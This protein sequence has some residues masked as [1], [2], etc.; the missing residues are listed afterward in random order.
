M[1]SGGSFRVFDASNPSDAEAWISMWESWPRRE[2]Q[3][4]PGYVKLF[5][6]P[7]SR[8]LCASWRSDEGCV[9][10]PL[11][12]RDAAT[13]AFCPPSIE[14]ATDIITPYG[15][16][17]PFC[18]G[19]EDT[20]SLADRFWR[21]FDEW[22]ASEVV[23]SEF[24]RFS[25]F[26]DTLLD[27][28]GEAEYSQDNI[29]RNLEPD[30]DAIIGDFKRKVRENAKKA[31]SMGATVEMDTTGARLD[32]FLRI[33]TLT[34]DRRNALES[35]YFPRS[36]FEQIHDEFA[37]RFVYFF[38]KFG[39]KTI[40]VQLV[41][42]SAE[43]AYGFL[44]GTDSEY[45]A[46]RP[47]DLM[48]SDIIVWLKRQGLRRYVLGGGYE[49]NDGIYQFKRSFA[50]TGAVPFR[51]GRRILNQDLYDQ[52]VECR[53]EAAESTGEPYPRQPDFFPIYRA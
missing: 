17:G 49:P 8:G 10:Y 12:L 44:G 20:R 5:A 27:Y 22:A 39:G 16:G 4:H 1:A 25:L 7:R 13:E 41:L 37:G 11:I 24:V 42:M 15:Y 18:W 21:S 30:E 36:L 38:A 9:L 14:R 32:E 23:V 35:Y 43:N 33:Y 51:L 2:L 40:S 6:G 29:V 31:E 46:V 34:M 50:P 28:P 3:A 26:N 52:L 19:T 47:N 48:F 53:R 45:F